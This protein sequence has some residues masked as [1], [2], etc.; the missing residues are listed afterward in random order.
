MSP[1]KL[2]DTCA[3]IMMAGMGTRL[4][5]ETPKVLHK[6]CGESLG[7]WVL[8]ACN[9]AG[10]KS[11]V[12]VVGHKAEVVQEAFEGETFALQSP[13]K[14]TGHA[15][16]V[17]L[18]SAPKDAKKIFVLSGDVPCL[19]PSTIKNILKYHEKS[20]CKATVLSFFPPDPCG[21]GRIVRDED[22][23]F[24][25][26]I[27]D[28]DLTGDPH[29]LGECNSGIY[30]FDHAALSVGLSKIK[31]SKRSGEYHLPDVLTYILKTGGKV[32]VIPAFDYMEA[33]GVNNRIELMEASDYLRWQIAEAHMIQG[34]TIID[35]AN[36]WIGP[37]VIIG[38]DCTINPGCILMGDT[39]IGEG[40]RI[41]PYA[42]LEN[43]IAGKNT[44]I[45]NS[46]CED[47]RIDEDAKIGPY[48]HIRPKSR[49]RKGARVGNFVEMKNTDFGDG[50]KCGHLT[51]LGDATV[52]KECNIGAGTITCN[53]DGEKKNNTVIEDG[54][55]VGSDSILVAPI[56]IGKE[57]YTAA[58]ST[59]TQ[60]VPPRALA[61]GRARQSVKEG[62][63]TTRMNA[64]KAREKK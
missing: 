37:R 13:Q 19:K 31:P 57:S 6:V 46:V 30:V 35:P 41:G 34:V 61:F 40:S 4:K 9:F 54:V 24:V 47:C 52:G 11:R 63:V 38:K 25:E 2:T 56:K 14:G 20:G 43:V 48:A 36:T 16:M 62:W 28:K 17:G 32:D 59:L 27:E 58:G 42:Q 23:E 39:K 33:V 45:Q 64:A 22:L 29:E 12:I 5:S 15:V 26:I 1:K 51:Y 7:R 49:I 21:Y 60:D 53:Y 50:S 55:F 8:D 18:K 10:L 3:I 44:K